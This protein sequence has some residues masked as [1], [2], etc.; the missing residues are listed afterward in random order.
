MELRAIVHNCNVTGQSWNVGHLLKV[1]TAVE[2]HERETTQWETGASRFR[3]WGLTVCR[4]ADIIGQINGAQ[5][6]VLHCWCIL[7]TY[8]WVVVFLF[9]HP[10]SYVALLFSLLLVVPQVRG[11]IAGSSLLS[12]VRFVACICIIWQDFG[13]YVA[14]SRRIRSAHAGRSQQLTRFSYFLRINSKS[15]HRGIW[16]PGATLAAFEGDH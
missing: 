12:P 4:G 7:P 8:T 14:D 5:R 9:S 6:R 15:H 2:A 11:H 1:H 16:S 3:N 10:I 13:P